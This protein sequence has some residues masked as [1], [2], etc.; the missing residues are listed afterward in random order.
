MTT[1]L[2]ISFWQ[3]VDKNGPVPACRPDLGPC[4]IWTGTIRGKGYGVFQNAQAHRFSWELM[5]GPFPAGL[6]A[7]HLCRTPRC[8]NPDHLE[9]VTDKEN[10]LRGVGAPAI[11][12]R[13]THCSRGHEFSKANTCHGLDGKRYCR[14]CRRMQNRISGY[15]AGRGVNPVLLAEAREFLRRAAG[16][17]TLGGST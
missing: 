3:Q 15:L 5:R 1:P 2:E 17:E 8:V 11:N 9:A 13:K 7:D 12:A 16:E 10:I 14:T 6:V 4:W